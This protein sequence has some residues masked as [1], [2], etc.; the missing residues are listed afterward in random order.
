LEKIGRVR[1]QIIVEAS[2]ENLSKFIVENIEENSNVI[3]DG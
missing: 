2:I 1:F 3:T